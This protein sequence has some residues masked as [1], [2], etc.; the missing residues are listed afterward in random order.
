MVPWTP[1]EIQRATCC[2]ASR[3]TSD[4]RSNT[5]TRGNWRMDP[6]LRLRPVGFDELGV[7]AALENCVNDRGR[8]DVIVLDM[9]LPG[10]SDIEILRHCAPAGRACHRLEPEGQLRNGRRPAKQVRSK[11]MA[12]A[13]IREPELSRGHLEAGAQ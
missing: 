2:K 10:V 4:W 5:S 11:I 12:A 6:Y 3:K 9:A 1:R 7:A 8:A 13:R